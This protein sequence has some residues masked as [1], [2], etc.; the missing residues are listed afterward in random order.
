MHQN[1]EVRNSALTPVY[2]L[3]FEE[4]VIIHIETGIK[5]FQKEW[6]SEFKLYLPQ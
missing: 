6:Y 3:T 1:R 2:F 5:K 4:G